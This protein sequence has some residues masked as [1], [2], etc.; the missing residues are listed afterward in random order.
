[1]SKRENIENFIGNTGYIC[2]KCGKIV[3]EGKT[4]ENQE[5]ICEDCLIAELQQQLTEKDKEIERLKEERKID[6]K[7]FDE[8]QDEY[9]KMLDNKNREINKLKRQLKN[10]RHQVC[11]EILQYL[12]DSKMITPENP[13]ERLK[14]NYN[15]LMMAD[16]VNACLFD[17]IEFVKDLEKG[18]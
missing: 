2:S 6:L 3:I 13:K 16:S 12:E 8:T 10:S 17:I 1:M 18:E 4:H 7:E 11:E 9:E 5:G 15:A 14:M